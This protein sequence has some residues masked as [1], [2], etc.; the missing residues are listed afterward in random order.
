MIATDPSTNWITQLPFGA[1]SVATLVVL[2]MSVL[3]VGLLHLSRKALFDYLD[4]ELIAKKCMET[5]QG[6]GMLA[7]S[8]AIF[9]LAVAVVINAAV[10]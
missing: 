5:S 8:L 2:L 1:N 6:A 9:T 4:F 3:Y 10:R 7:V